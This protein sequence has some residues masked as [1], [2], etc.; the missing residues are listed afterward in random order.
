MVF[1][2]HFTL[3]A[4]LNHLKKKKKFIDDT[5]KRKPTQKKKIKGRCEYTKSE[6]TNDDDE[7][8]K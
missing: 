4:F 2:N 7:K 1:F 6:L 5:I 3:N 8:K